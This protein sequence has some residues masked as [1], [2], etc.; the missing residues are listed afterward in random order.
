MLKACSEQVR[1][2]GMKKIIE[3][4]YYS[5]FEGYL[6]IQFILEFSSQK[7][8]IKIWDGY[9]NSIMECIKPS[10]AGWTGLAYYY[11][12]DIGWYD[13]SPWEIPDLE[14]AL[15]QFRTIYL[16]E[17]KEEEQVILASIIQLLEEACILNE[18]VYIDY[19]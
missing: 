5:R 12:L 9:F 10:L 13:E 8:V 1:L 17:Q 4:D 3:L 11:H 7:K 18:K 14:L 6:E 15:E 2:I 19:S 16:P